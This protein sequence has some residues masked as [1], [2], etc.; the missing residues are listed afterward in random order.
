MGD[1]K[2]MP[3]FQAHFTRD[4][5]SIREELIIKYIVS[6]IK[7]TNHQGNGII[8][9]HLE[10]GIIDWAWPLRFVRG[11]ETYRG[12]RYYS[13]EARDAIQDG[14]TQ[15]RRDHFFPKNIFKEL[16]FSMNNRDPNEVRQFMEKYGEICVITIQEDARLNAAGLRGRMP[17]GWQ[18]EDG[19]IFA[20]Y[21]SVGINV[22]INDRQW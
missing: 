20:R 15:F 18:I 3:P 10:N 14:E 17:Q 8:P 16:L 5:V 12:L 13:H 21:Q 19:N 9:F 1:R 7:D 11:N 4:E 6:L 2:N 22:W